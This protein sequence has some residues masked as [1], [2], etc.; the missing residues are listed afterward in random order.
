[1]NKNGLTYGMALLF[2]LSFVLLGL[3]VVNEKKVD[4]MMPKIEDKLYSYIDENYKDI[5]NEINIGK[6]KYENEKKRFS[7]K[8]TNTKSKHLYFHLYYKNKKITSTF[9]SDY[10]EGRTLLNYL[11]KRIEKKINLE[12]LSISITTPLNKFSEDVEN[13]LLKEED[14]ISLKIYTIIKEFSLED[15]SQN[16]IITTIRTLETTL[17]EKEI[18]PKD[19]S[20]TFTNKLD[21]TQAFKIEKLTL[22]NANL[23][24][25]IFGILNHDKTIENQ[26][27]IKYNYLN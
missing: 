17:T 10:K 2:L 27:N 5:Q 3:I 20:L 8:I 6:V 19:Y 23:N 7:L 1:M 14:L 24:Q 22:P 26:Y 16:Q 13:R 4:I 12:N 18:N 21:I 11:E 9:E 15:F 25:I